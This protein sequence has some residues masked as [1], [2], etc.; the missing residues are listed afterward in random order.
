M[1]LR[2]NS[3]TPYNDEMLAYLDEQIKEERQITNATRTSQDRLNGILDQLEVGQACE[4]HN[5]NLWRWRVVAQHTYNT[6][7]LWR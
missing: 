5:D 3:I 6:S 1:F 7:D 4:V 2:M